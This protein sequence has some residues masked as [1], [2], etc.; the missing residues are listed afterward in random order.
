MG[1]NGNPEKPRV[2]LRVS[3]RKPRMM[4]D[5]DAGG[6]KMFVTKRIVVEPCM[7]KSF[8][9]NRWIQRLVTHVFRWM[10]TFLYGL[11][12][13]QCLCFVGTR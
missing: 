2:W 11:Q 7:R 1:C 5:D 4:I 13:T 3:Q 9:E 10:V 8:L 6:V 12:Q